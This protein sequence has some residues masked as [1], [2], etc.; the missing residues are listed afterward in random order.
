[1]QP[2]YPLHHQ[3]VRSHAADNSPHIIEETAQLADFRF[4]GSLVDNGHSVCQHRRQYG[5]FRGPHAGV[6]QM[7]F[8]SLKASVLSASGLYGTIPFPDIG[9]QGP[10]CH[11]MQVNGPGPYETSARITAA[12]LA[13]AS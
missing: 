11:Q 6:G 9:S 12:A 1:M 8:C 10:Q 13:H 2:G 5:L 3:M 4:P 7:D